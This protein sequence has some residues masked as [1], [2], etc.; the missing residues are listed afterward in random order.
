MNI[1]FL[2]PPGAGKGTHAQRLMQELSIPQISTGEI[3]RAAIREGTPTGLKAKA[4]IE[5]GEL[6]PDAV[7]IDIVKERLQQADCANGYILD[8]FPRTVAQAEALGT[9][10]KIDAVVNFILS[11]DAIIRR[12]SGRRVCPKCGNTTHI[13]A[14][15]GSTVC[16]VCGEELVQRKD[17]LPETVENRL[18]VYAEQ[19][20][21]L[22][23]YY[24]A[25]G[26][27]RDIV[28]D[29]HIVDENHALVRQSLGLED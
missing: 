18:K 14:L 27:V 24:Q 3:L 22:I 1:I 2:G 26:L 5:K 11:D 21:P 20:A 16:P 10:A 25:R 9:F 6:V 7:V 17:D 8:G 29:G 19:T 13:S 28:C 15:N 23:S 12:L 4:C